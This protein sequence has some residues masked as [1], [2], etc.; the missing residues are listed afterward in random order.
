MLS[1]CKASEG[2]EHEGQMG[3]EVRLVARGGDGDGTALPHA[4]WT[5]TRCY[6]CHLSPQKR[7]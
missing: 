2:R 3:M 4:V 5:L 1:T 7:W 6:R